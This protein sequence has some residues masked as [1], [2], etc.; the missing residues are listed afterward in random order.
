MAQIERTMS[1]LYVDIL[2]AS[3]LVV[4]LL[5]FAAVYWHASQYGIVGGRRL[6]LATGVGLWC[7]AGFLVPTVFEEQLQRVYFGV[8]KPGPIAVSP[9]EWLFVSL[10]VGLLLSVA[11]VGGYLMGIRY[12]NTQPSAATS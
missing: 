6:L 3:G 10:A 11:G 4:G 9:F 7:L 8:L 12:T 5:V 1:A 2:R